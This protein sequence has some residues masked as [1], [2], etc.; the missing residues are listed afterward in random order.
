MKNALHIAITN[1]NE[2]LVKILFELDKDKAQY[3]G[4]ED[5]TGKVP[6]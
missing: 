6:S 2:E 3:I 1:S 4:G 5:I